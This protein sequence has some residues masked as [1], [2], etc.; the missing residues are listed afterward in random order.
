MP[1]TICLQILYRVPFSLLRD[2][3][4]QKY[5]FQLHPIAVAPSLRVLQHCELRL[6]DLEKCPLKPEECIL[7]VG[8]PA[9]EQDPLLGTGEEVKHLKSCF[10]GRVKALEKNEAT[11]AKFLEQVKE[12]SQS[13][14]GHIFAF[15]HLGVHGH[16]REIRAGATK[17]HGDEENRLYKTGSLQFAKPPSP[18]ESNTGEV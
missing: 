9:Y 3:E 18:D 12:L 5:L 1:R 10:P 16:W 15:I 2:K 6:R 13:K 11:R 8:N 14:E 4:T 17:S 7:S